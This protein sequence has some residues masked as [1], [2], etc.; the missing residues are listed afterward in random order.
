M[1]PRVLFLAA[2]ALLL[3]VAAPAR[4]EG[5]TG[6][7]AAQTG[8][9][10]AT[11]GALP[12]QYYVDAPAESPAPP[13][14]AAVPPGPAPYEPPPP[15][16]GY[17]PPAVVYEPP[18]PPVPRHE[19]PKTSLW[20]GVRGGWFIPF[21]NLW[22]RCPGG[23]CSDAT[24]WSELA[25]SGPMLEL[26]AGLRFS[27]YYSVFATWEHAELGSGSAAPS[28]QSGADSDYYAVGLRFSSN[29]DR[30]GFLTELALGFRRFRAVYADGSEDQLT[31]APFEFRAGIGVDLRLSSLVTLEP[32]LTLG[33]G[34]FGD[35][36]H[37][38]PNG[39]SSSLTGV[40]DRQA[41]HAWA[42]FQLGAHFD[43][44][45]KD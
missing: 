1:K 16:Y 5:G 25:S 14:A 30:V 29:P 35:A 40:D 11:P 34:A 41:G 24:K 39:S 19:A 33:A 21:G 20:L 15:G 26:D 6:E 31:N 36:Q 8:A 4:A 13:E 23:Y 9:A 32:M 18:P 2:P 37:V 22:A 28:A 27:R 42:T 3:A 10:P 38:G 45:G 44:F 17:G 12:P 7:A 43:L